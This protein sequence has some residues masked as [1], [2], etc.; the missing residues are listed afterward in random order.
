MVASTEG[1][2]T[3]EADDRVLEIVR[4]FAAPRALVFRMWSEPEHIV[5]WH[6]PEGFWLTHCEQ[7]FRIGGAWRRCMSNGPGHEHWIS[8]VFREIREPE[9]LSFT[10]IN[11]YDGHEMLVEMDFLDRGHETEMHFRQSQFANVAERDGHGWGWNSGFDLLAAYLLRLNPADLRPVGAPRID[12]VAADI[13]AARERQE[14]EKRAAADGRRSA[15]EPAAPD[16]KPA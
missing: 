15:T 1:K 6:G 13:I 12:G 9:R 8:G 14:A 10:Y 2:A 4:T 11:D 5:R 16:G 7:D 3:A